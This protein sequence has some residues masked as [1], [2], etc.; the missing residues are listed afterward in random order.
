MHV[1]PGRPLC[2]ATFQLYYH[3]AEGR[4]FVAVIRNR[5]TVQCI[6]FDLAWLTSAR[7]FVDRLR[8]CRS[9]D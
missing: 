8:N 9:V 3:T 7:G 6:K 1:T 4:G 5:S 2:S